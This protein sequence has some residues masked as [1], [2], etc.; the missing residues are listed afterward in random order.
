MKWVFLAD[1]GVV[2][3]VGP[4]TMHAPLLASIRARAQGRCPTAHAAVLAPPV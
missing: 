4:H 2:R 3:R 1:Y